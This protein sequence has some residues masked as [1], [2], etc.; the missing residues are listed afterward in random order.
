MELVK[1][2]KRV[3]ILCVEFLCA[4]YAGAN[5]CFREIF[6]GCANILFLL[7]HPGVLGGSTPQPA[8]R[9]CFSVCGVCFFGGDLISGYLFF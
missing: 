5:R 7:A 3:S 9:F 4:L 8:W 6:G 2:V 1:D